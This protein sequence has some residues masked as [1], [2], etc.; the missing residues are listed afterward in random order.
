MKNT[1]LG[2]ISK[3]DFERDGYVIIPDLLTMDEADLLR[4]VARAD[5]DIAANRSSRADGEGGAVELVVRNDLPEDSIYGAI[6]RAQPLVEVMEHLLGDE[7]YHYHHKM[8]LKEPRTGGAWT[9][10]Q[11]YGYWYNNGCLFPDMASCMI[12]VD[13]ATKENGCLQVIRGSH[14]MG[15]VDHV[16]RGDQTGADQERI[17]A[18]LQQLELVNVELPPGS[19]VVFHGNTLHRSDQNNS[20]NPRWA[21]ICCYNTK[22]NNPW[23]ESKHPRYS[24]LERWSPDR[25]AETGAQQLS[26]L[27]QPD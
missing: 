12:A 15:R 21:F 11:D 17:D 23:K 25:I 24:P 14:K 18:A 7:V 2:T 19:A 4:K 9:W 8:I 20:E 16:K 6:V 26:R 22:H 3:S 10:H 1:L 13:Q 27:H 5:R